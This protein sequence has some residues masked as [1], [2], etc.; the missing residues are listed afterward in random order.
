MHIQPPSFYQTFSVTVSLL[1]LSFCF[2]LSVSLIFYHT[3]RKPSLD[4]SS[5]ILDSARLQNYEKVILR[6][7]QVCGFMTA[8]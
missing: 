7:G 8:I 1:L 5:L 6:N 2:C 3:T 4:A